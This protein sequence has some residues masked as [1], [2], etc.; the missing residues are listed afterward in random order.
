MTILVRYVFR[1]IKGWLLTCMVDT[2][3]LFAV[4]EL[5]AYQETLWETNRPEIGCYMKRQG[6]IVHSDGFVDMQPINSGPDRT[7]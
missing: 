1:E 4:G 3:R 6:A 2:Y 5:N 7:D